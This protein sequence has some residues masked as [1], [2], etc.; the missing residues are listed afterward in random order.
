MEFILEQNEI[1]EDYKVKAKTSPVVVVWRKRPTKGILFL[2]IF[3]VLV[4][5]LIYYFI[6]DK[7]V[8]PTQEENTCAVNTT[9]RIL[10]GRTDINATY[11]YCTDIKCCFDNSTRY[12]YHYLPSKYYYFNKGNEKTYQRS[13]SKSPFKQDLTKAI[14]L[15]INEIDENN[16]QIILH[17]VDATVDTNTVQNKNY[18]VNISQDPM[19]VEVFRNDSKDLLL[20]TANGPTIVSG[21]FIE[22]SFQLTESYLFGLGQVLIDLDENSTLTKVIYAN[23]LDHNTLPVFMANTNGK[24]HGIVVKHSGLLEITVLPSKLVSLKS[25][26]REKIVLELSVGPTPHD[27]IKQQKKDWGNVDMKTLGV[28]ICR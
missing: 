22:W 8:Y 15:S 21:N 20:T 25:L 3:S 6:I 7:G 26:E 11:E 14:S 19:F 18:K 13:L 24:Y 23:N 4:P 27:V 28:H 16:L 17:H 2:L 12:C 1:R 5:I 10:C 9:F